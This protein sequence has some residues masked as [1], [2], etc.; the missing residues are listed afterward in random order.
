MSVAYF[1]A[2]GIYLTIDSCSA[3][4][5]EVAWMGDEEREVLLAAAKEALSVLSAANAKAA[6]IAREAED[7]AVAHLLEQQASAAA[8]LQQAQDPASEGA[9][10]TEDASTLLEMHRSAAEL[11]AATEKE[12]AATLS[13]T[14]TNAAVDVLMA[15]HREAAAILLGAWMRVT[16]GRPPDR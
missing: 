15:G 10:S 13:A 9:G 7:D 4:P 12:V 5:G 6:R 11:L 8:L 1:R 14:K 2:L 3:L 16:E